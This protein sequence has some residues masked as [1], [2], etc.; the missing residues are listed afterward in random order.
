MAATPVGATTAICFAQ[1]SLMY[2]RKVVFPVP[3]L[4]VRKT[5]HELCL[6]NPAASPNI[7]LD[8]S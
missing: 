1:F 5:L 3:A 6:I 8:R 2:L 4:P 7:S